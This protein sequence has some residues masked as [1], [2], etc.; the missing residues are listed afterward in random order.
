MGS[1]RWGGESDTWD[2]IQK[3]CPSPTVTHWNERTE[4]NQEVWLSEQWKFKGRNP[5]FVGNEGHNIQFQQSGLAPRMRAQIDILKVTFKLTVFKVKETDGLNSLGHRFSSS[6]Q[7][8]PHHN[9]PGMRGQRDV[10]TGD[11]QVNCSD[12][13][14]SLVCKVSA[15]KV[16]FP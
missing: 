15:L 10:R 14:G 6:S 5:D 2:S 7:A 11:C 9:V 3:S 12:E 4:G 1:C 16:R 8:L 13:M